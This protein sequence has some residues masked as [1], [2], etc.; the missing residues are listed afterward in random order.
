MSKSLISSNQLYNRFILPCLIITR[1]RWVS[2]LY[3]EFSLRAPMLTC[4]NSVI[5]Q[6]PVMLYGNVYKKGRKRIMLTSLPC[7]HTEKLDAIWNSSRNRYQNITLNG[8]PV[9][10]WLNFITDFKITFSLK[11]QKLHFIRKPQKIL[12]LCL[13]SD[14]TNR[15]CMPF[16]SY[17]HSYRAE[18]I[19]CCRTLRSKAT[20]CFDVRHVA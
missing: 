11:I 6:Y 1:R 16:L 19:S 9:A 14:V 12:F 5:R 18:A 8:D 2:S 10:E 3:A 4:C 15:H 20:M 13:H 7:N 17:C